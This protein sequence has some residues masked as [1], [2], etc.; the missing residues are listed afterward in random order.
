MKNKFGKKSLYR[1]Q[2]RVGY[3]LIVP[4]FLLFIVFFAYSLVQAFHYSLLDWDG[5]G[6]QVYIGFQNYVELFQDVVFG[7]AF[8]N[9]WL[10]T[11]GLMLFG[12][13]PGLIL[14]YLLSGEHIIGRTFFRSV[15]FFPR[16]VS[17]VIYGVVWKWI[18]DPR[19][20]LLTMIIDALGGEGSSFAMLGDIKTAMLGITITG[21]WTY[22][23][24]CMVIFLAAFMGIDTSLK[25]SAV[26]D[27]ANKFQVFWKVVIP[28]I[29][30]VLNTVII[31]TVIDSFKVYDL[32][33]VMTNGGPNEST[34][35]MTYYIYKQ[36]F[37]MNRFGYGSAAAILL[38]IVMVIF[39]I[40]YNKSFGK[41]EV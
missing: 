11:I 3:A 18:Y 24:F 21:G 28:Q 35:V 9:S 37:T 8:L 20:G 34:Q 6:K 25:E 23:G 22:F 16:I 30:P 36:A 31:Y 4:A 32:V 1:N 29:K 12:V 7:K 19:K 33:L 41:E 15:Y 10:Y 5:V 14:A 40:I 39:T 38:G 17:A 2:M 27:G 13:L 26:L